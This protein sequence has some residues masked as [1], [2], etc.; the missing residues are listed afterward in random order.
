[1]NL[2]TQM[3]KIH[4][5]TSAKINALILIGIILL[6]LYTTKIDEGFAI[7]LTKDDIPPAQLPAISHVEIDEQPILALNDII[8]YNANTHEITLTS[9]AFN[10]ISSL[11]V[12]VQGKS[13]VVCI[14][15]KPIYCGAFWTPISSISFNGVTIWKP[16]HSQ[17]LKTIKLELGYPSPNFYGGEDPRNKAE[18]LKSLK[19]AGKLIN[20]PAQATVYGLPHS[21]KVYELRAQ[22]R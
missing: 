10:R 8:T 16:L 9:S 22:Y 6:S 1:M 19:Q 3:R 5:P 14:D 7:Y 20:K 4:F 2:R 11:D 13:F 15:K 18:I 12:S 21:I 17:E